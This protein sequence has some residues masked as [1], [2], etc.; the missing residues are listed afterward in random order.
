[1]D[2][3]SESNSIISLT[4]KLLDSISNK[5]W[6]SYL[7]LCDEKL[8]GIEKESDNSLVEGLEFHKFYFDIPNDN[9]IAIKETI[10][11]PVIKIHGD[12][13]IIC[14]KRLRTTVNIS[15]NITNSVSMMET[16]IWRH[17][18]TGWKLIHFQKS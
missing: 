15:T 16:R 12:I 7:A 9:N 2:N 18:N 17:Y 8:T 14:Y 5:D 4:Q 6:D 1:M 11:Q 13:G 10:L 3:G